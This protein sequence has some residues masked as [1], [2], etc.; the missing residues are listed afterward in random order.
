MSS[1]KEFIEFVQSD[2]ERLDEF[3]WRT[4][5]TGAA[6]AGS[7]L[8][9]SP[10]PALAA[11]PTEIGSTRR[12]PGTSHQTIGQKNNN[13]INLKGTY[14]WKG[15]VGKDKYGHAIFKTLD[16]G[17]RAS[18][19]NLVVHQR[20]NP[21]QTLRQYMRVFKTKPGDY[22]ANYIAKYLGVSPDSKLKDLNMAEVLIP[23]ARIETT[24]TLSPNQIN[25]VR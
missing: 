15:M 14:D 19:K 12:Q 7:L 21:N 10:Q 24:L 23:L 16:D 4:A 2:T 20:R 22:Q 3:N 6:I 11:A 13:P 8:T 25:L 18:L 5:A 17:I 1:L 9:G